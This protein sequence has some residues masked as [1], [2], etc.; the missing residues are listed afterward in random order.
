MEKADSCNADVALAYVSAASML[1]SDVAMGSGV[2]RAVMVST[3]EGEVDPVRIVVNESVQMG[4]LVL[5]ANANGLLFVLDAR[6]KLSGSNVSL[7]IEVC[8]EASAPSMRPSLSPSSSPAAAAYSPSKLP[9]HMPSTYNDAA[10]QSVCNADASWVSVLDHDW[11]DHSAWAQGYPP[12]KRSDLV[13]VHSAGNARLKV[14]T[15]VAVGTLVLSAAESGS[16]TLKLNATLSLFG[17]AN[18]TV[19]DVQVKLN[20]MIF[21]M[22]SLVSLT[23]LLLPAMVTVLSEARSNYFEQP[24]WTTVDVDPINNPP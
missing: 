20:K 18:R 10:T 24:N 16:L 9:S 2:K 22:I 12:T 11:A 19:H 6:M 14:K 7:P 17:S 3:V 1:W 4:S 13:S 23:K 15:A 8:A 21:R 5:R